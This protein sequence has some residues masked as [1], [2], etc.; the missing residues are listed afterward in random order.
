[1]DAIGELN[2]YKNTLNTAENILFVQ[3]FPG[4]KQVTDLTKPDIIKELISYL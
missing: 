3:S 1:M 2:E 4:F